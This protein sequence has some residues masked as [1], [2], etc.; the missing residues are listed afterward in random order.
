[1]TMTAVLHAGCA[2]LYAALTGLILVQSKV[3]RTGLALAGASLMT[4]IWALSV[5]ID[6]AVPFTGVEGALDL[7]RSAAWYGFILQM[8]RQA[9]PGRGVVGQ[10]F[11]VTGTVVALV[12]VVSLVIGMGN[13]AVSLWSTGT[14]VRIGLAVC[15]I[16][17]IENLYLN[18]PDEAKWHINLPCV[19]LGALSVYDIVLSADAVLFRQVSGPLF[20][21]RAVATAIV[22]PLLAVAAARNRA[23]SIKIH[24]SR[25]AVF[26]SATLIGSGIFL[27]GLALAGEAF[28]Y[29]GPGWGGVA[30]I[31]MMFGGLVVVAVVLSSGSARGRIRRVVVD[32]FFTHRFDYRREWM[33]CIAILSAPADPANP[34][35][36]VPLHTRVIR[37]VSE[38]V[39]APGGVLFLQE[40]LGE[41]GYQWAG[42]WNMPAVSQIVPADGGLVAALRGG[43]WIVVLPEG[44]DDGPRATLPPEIARAWLVVPLRH[45]EAMIGFIV[46]SNPRAGF[47]LDREVYDLLRIIGLQV[48]TTVAEQRATEVLLQAREMH[49]YGK[50][51]AFVAHDIKNVSSQLSLLLSNAEVHLANP[52]FQRD[53]LATVRAS[54]AKI[55]ALLKRLQ[56]PVTPAT[57]TVIRP[58][59]RLDALV[60]SVARLRR[61]KVLLELEDRSAAVAMPAVAFDAAVTHLLTN[62][63]EATEE[64]ARSGTRAALPPDAIRVHARHE[65]RRLLIDIVDHGPGMSAEFIREQLFRP[66]ETSKIG[67]SGI[68]AFQ[69]RELLRDIGGDLLVT[70]APGRGTTMRLLLPLVDVST[71]ESLPTLA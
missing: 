17:L 42:S 64:A 46:I 37:A 43:Y 21:G 59:E 67:G 52:E 9:V 3:S 13:G 71:S 56:G 12:I 19:A 40:R 49:D 69:A 33:R 15:N 51:F 47:K 27:L 70:S 2:A 29:F 5:A 50:R 25:S 26:H 8:Y 16:L 57:R 24:V 7:L 18:A 22:A 41:G 11:A 60:T 20:E 55:S 38:I 68:G 54:V 65:G 61:Q 66:F 1:M 6:L 63:I 34:L 58:V 53:M 31:S 14:G 39:D 32:N 45:G 4:A 28:R 35:A 48:A 44:P 62:A 36:Y 30:E 23:W 10:A